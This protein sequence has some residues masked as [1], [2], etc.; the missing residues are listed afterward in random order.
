MTTSGLGKALDDP[1]AAPA[2]V[3]APA[4]VAPVPDTG[5]PSDDFER[6]RELL[7]GGERRELAAARARI[8]E[9]ERTQQDLPRR[10][11]GAPMAPP[12]KAVM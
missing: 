11:P 5:A 12:H 10:L 2:A 4:D 3:V 1:P 6:L 7:L 9:L 8:T